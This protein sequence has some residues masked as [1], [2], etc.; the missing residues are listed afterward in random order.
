MATAAQTP[1]RGDVDLV[2]NRV[3][4]VNGQRFSQSGTAGAPTTGHHNAGDIHFDWST[5]KLWGCTVSGNPGTWK[6]VALS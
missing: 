3:L 1:L 6:G 5:P 4:S 2:R